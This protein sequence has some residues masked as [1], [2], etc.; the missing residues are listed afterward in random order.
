M[1]VTLGGAQIKTELDLHSALA[2]SL[3]FGPH[4]GNN[5]AALWDRLTSDVERP[6]EVVWSNSAQSR[7]ALGDELFG[8]VVKLMRDVEEQDVSFG[9]EDRFTLTLA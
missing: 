4:Y 8:R 7:V 9:W 2:N 5:L 3:N 1:Q 6:V